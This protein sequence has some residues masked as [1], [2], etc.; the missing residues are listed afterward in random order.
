MVSGSL[1]RSDDRLASQAMFQ[2]VSKAVSPVNW[3]SKRYLYLNVSKI[4]RCV[5][6]L[7]RIKDVPNQSAFIE[8]HRRGLR[9]ISTWVWCLIVN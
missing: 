6:T 2:L 3:C 9:L 8:K 1:G 5:L 4:K 7:E